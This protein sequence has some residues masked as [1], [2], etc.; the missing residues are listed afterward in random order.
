MTILRATRRREARE[1]KNKNY[2]WDKLKFKVL[3][4]PHLNLNIFHAYME[5]CKKRKENNV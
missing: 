3:K 2:Y 1:K 4:V 5:K